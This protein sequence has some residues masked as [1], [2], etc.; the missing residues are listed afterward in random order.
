MLLKGP[1]VRALA[2]NK[3]EFQKPQL[4][5]FIHNEH[6]GEVLTYLS[7]HTYVQQ[8]RLKKMLFWKVLFL[9]LVYPL[10]LVP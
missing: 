2:H 10:L 4:T 8:K 5:L 3:T 6:G 9:I 7:V 1:K